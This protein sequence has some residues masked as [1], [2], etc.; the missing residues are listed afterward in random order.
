MAGKRLRELPRDYTAASLH[1]P[2]FLPHSIPWA[3]EASQ[4]RDTILLLGGHSRLSLQF[5]TRTKKQPSLGTHTTHT[6]PRGGGREGGALAS[7]L[8]FLPRLS[9]ALG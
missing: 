6:P 4:G 9:V 5:V 7:C 2:Q 8:P 1:G 3:L